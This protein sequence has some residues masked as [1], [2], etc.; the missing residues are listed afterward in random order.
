MYTDEKLPEFD[1]D[2]RLQNTG[3]PSGGYGCITL[4]FMLALT[5]IPLTFIY[6]MRFVT[7]FWN[8]FW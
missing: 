1:T 2:P 4:Y 7:W 3:E 8:N 5:L 6:F